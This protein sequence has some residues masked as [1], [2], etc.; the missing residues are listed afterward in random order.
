[1]SDVTIP[2]A[3]AV[4]PILF[5]I[6]VFYLAHLDRQDD[7]P[8]PGHPRNCRCDSCREEEEYYDWMELQGM[9]DALTDK[10]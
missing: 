2:M 6:V 5:V 7:P 4:P 9:M 3:C 1:M 8:A 10:D